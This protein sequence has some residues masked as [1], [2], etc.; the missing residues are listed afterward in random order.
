MAY[1]GKPSAR[2]SGFT[3]IEIVIAVAILAIMAG[4]IAPFVFREIER[5]REEATLLELAALREG[6]LE[7]YDDTGR[8]P[9]EG[10][11]LLALVTDPTVGGWSGP[12][13]GGEAGDFRARA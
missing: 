8:F 7:F 13:V 4:S 9:T 12:Y 3:L 2:R 6:M 11:G 5:A 10:E 1:N